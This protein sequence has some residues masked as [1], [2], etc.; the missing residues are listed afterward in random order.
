MNYDFFAQSCRYDRIRMRQR[1]KDVARNLCPQRREEHGFARQRHTA[2]H[3]YDLWGHERDHLGN[4]PTE[5]LQGASED[6]L[7]RHVARGCR[8]NDHA[9]AELL[10]PAAATGEKVGRGGIEGI[11]PANHARPAVAMAKPLECD[12][13]VACGSSASKPGRR[14]PISEATPWPPE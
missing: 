7:R 14:C 10:N 11:R 1:R 8:I 4:G 3:D 5:C 12:S 6:P 9:A 2:A 13:T